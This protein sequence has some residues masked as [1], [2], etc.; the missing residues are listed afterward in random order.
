MNLAELH[1]VKNGC[2]FVHA[3]IPTK[4]KTR[5]KW[6]PGNVPKEST[7]KK[8]RDCISAHKSI[9]R[10]E[11][12][13]KS[14]VSMPTLKLALDHLVEVGRIFIVFKGSCRVERLSTNI[15]PD[16]HT[17]KPATFKYEP[18]DLVVGRVIA[19][20]KDSGWVCV[21]DISL[22]LNLSHN[23][24]AVILRGLKKDGRTERKVNKIRGVYLRLVA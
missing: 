6:T 11:L 7:L 3:I 19:E 2:G 15:C 22:A 4:N 8:V 5:G 14:G 21:K 10:K 24:I 9:T 1:K 18:S 20:L 23:T 12:S 17:K 13:V 16:G